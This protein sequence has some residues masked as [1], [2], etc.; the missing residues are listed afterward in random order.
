MEQEPGKSCRDTP[1]DRM[2]VGDGAI[3]VDVHGVKA[4]SY[5]ECPDRAKKRKCKTA[6]SRRSG[7]RYISKFQNRESFDK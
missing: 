7:E 4:E 3:G 5:D 6:T 2:D 1:P